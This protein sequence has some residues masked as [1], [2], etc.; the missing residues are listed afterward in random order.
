MDSDVLRIQQVA[1]TFDPI[2]PASMRDL[3]Q[4]LDGYSAILA[5][6]EPTRQKLGD[7]TSP[8]IWLVLR[9][10]WGLTSVMHQGPDP[11]PELRRLYMDTC[12]SLA[13]FT[14]NLVAE[15]TANQMKAL[16]I[17][18]DSLRGPRV[19][20]VLLD[21]LASFFEAESSSE[22][23]RAFDIG[24]EIFSRI[25][26]AELIPKLYDKLALKDE[27]ITPPQ[28]TLLKLVDS[29]LHHSKSSHEL[30][31][32]RSEK[33][34]YCLLDML[35]REFLALS[36]YMQTSIRR[37]LG[38]P[39]SDP[40]TSPSL[41]ELDLLL[42]KV[43]EG[44]VLVAQCLTTIT[45]RG[46]ETNTMNPV[47]PSTAAGSPYP[48]S[49][50][51]G[52]ITSE[53]LGQEFVESLIELLRLIDTLVPRITY[54]K[55][56]EVPSTQGQEMGLNATPA[57]ASNRR[58]PGHDPKRI[59]AAQVFAHIKRDLVRLLGIL[60]SDNRAV[61]DHVRECGGLPVVMNLCVID[62]YNPCEPY[63]QALRKVS[64][65][66]LMGLLT[67]STR[68]CYFCAQKPPSREFRKPGGRGQ[69]Q[70]CWEV[71]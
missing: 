37:G 24:C 36:T 29:F 32:R 45:L 46:Q 48:L 57:V 9:H 23:G 26:K 43:C 67:R 70:A 63:F 64:P 58:D 54:G 53:F 19:C 5:R 69:N 20:L 56:V 51:A 65:P 2:N 39:G 28:T 18:V 3:V 8:S 1:L 55:V 59:Q 60:A 61:Q 4:V 71:G 11:V 25:T 22:E 47:P 34:G 66:V 17:L 15:N 30:S 14:R 31:S 12:A 10:L 50:I 13:K 27:P 38:S 33:G 16:E 68:A 40:D 21:R 7:S 6:S 49:P 62:D 44:L 35:A 41:Q 52:M 42:P